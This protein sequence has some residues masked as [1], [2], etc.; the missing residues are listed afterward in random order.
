M[1]KIDSAYAY[2][3]STY[4]N[5][6]V[7]RYDSH[8]KSD[9]RKVYNR[10]IKTN[11]E[12]PL[13]KISNMTDAKKYAIDI[14]ESSKAI[15]NAVDSLSDKYADS[16]DSF[17][18]KVA[19]SSDSDSVSV[20][21]VGDGSEDNSANQFNIE[22]KHLAT[23][24]VNTGNYL[25]S[26]ALSFLPGNYSFD[27]NTNSSSYEFQFGVNTG[28]TNG[29]VQEK[30]MRLVNNSGLGIEADIIRDESGK[31]ALQ[32]T[33][34]QTGL[35]ESE[36]Y[37]F[38][39]SPSATSESINAMK[40]LGINQVSSEA[41]S[42]EFTLNGKDHS[43]LSNT[44][45]INNAFE[46]TLKK[47]NTNT[48]GATIGFKAN[49]DAVADNVQ[50]LVDAYNNMIDVASTYSQTDSADA[51]KLLYDMGSI[52][53]NSQASLSYIGLMVDD[54]GKLTIDRDILS[55]ALRPDRADDT[56]ATLTA[57]KDAIGDKA[58]NVTINPMNYVQ[59]VVVAYKNPG[60]NFNTP[61]ISSIYSGMMLDSYA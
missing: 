26:N 34:I 6:E 1:A 22:V 31:S 33:S 58:N 43:S 29:E 3:A 40:L 4:A 39:I 54:S 53:Q 60:R 13:Y 48:N 61:Y 55:D 11:K 7:S 10:I 14:K 52:T 51:H 20:K 21:Y 45:T 28:E 17:Q 46:L 41:S 49:S 25:D 50:T 19:E 18:K 59:K 37:L 24:Q 5:R 30:L 16:A 12:S 2:Y 35:S 36:D 56:F 57:L 38:S 32:L 44:F 9:L 23:P 8:K 15:L 42:S 47:P 27:L